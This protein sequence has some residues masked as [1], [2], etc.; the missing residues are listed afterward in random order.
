MHEFLRGIYGSITKI[1][2]TKLV[3]NIENLRGYHRLLK[4]DRIEYFGEKIQ[5]LKLYGNLE[6]YEDLADKYLVR[7]YVEKEIGSKY[8][9]EL[10]DVYDSTKEINFDQL[11]KSFVL[12]LNTGSGCNIICKDKDYFDKD[13]AIKKLN[14]WLKEDFSKQKKEPQYK[15]IK[16]KILCEKYMEDN[17]GQLLDYKFFCF[18][19][20]VEF[21]KVNFDRFE[22]HKINFYDTDWNLLNFKGNHPHYFGKVEKPKNLDKMIEISEKL[23]ISTGL[24]FVRIDLYNI[25]GEIY[26]G[27]IT[28]TPNSGKAIFKPIEKDLEYA[29]KIE[30]DSY[31][32]PK[33]LMIASLAIENDRLDGET[34]KN[35]TFK[36]YLESTRKFNIRSVDTHYGKKHR[37]KM[38]FDIIKNYLW[39]EQIIVS[40]SSR[41]ASVVIRF[42]NFIKNKKP[43]YY[44]VIGGYLSKFIDEGKLKKSYYVNLDNIYVESEILKNDLNRQG[45]NN[46]EVIHN[47]RKVDQFENRYQK[48]DFIK[49][50]FYGRIMKT[51]GI[52]QAIELIKKLTGENYKVSLDIYG[53]VEPEYLEELKQKMYGCEN[54][55]YCNVITPDSKTEYE[56][57]SQYD[58]F[59]FPTEHKG[60]GLPG[61]LIDC[62]IAGVAVLVSDW[63]Y[64][65]EYVE[66][67]ENGY[68]FEYR[69]YADMYIKAKQMIDQNKIE[70]FKKES[71]KLSSSYIVGDVLEDF[72]KRLEKGK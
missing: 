34:I 7:D 35:K 29:K 60:E 56:I 31:K 51:K 17:Q 58:V 11:P 36:S 16:K 30:L 40:N 2:P 15:N 47:F 55:R 50:V 22:G 52:E 3:L 71:L 66:D 27:E 13:K 26:F 44:F 1:L 12:K 57:L 25:D 20:K 39:C 42:F 48:S 61:A 72:V 68:I 23:A 33:I 41:G 70:E 38:S 37:I 18:N 64:A 45:L 67:G 65:R 21:L 59:V 62:Y 24:S 43:I 53:Q 10:I 46:V 4:K 19:G 28:L 14:K 32:K 54:I 63:T 8:L 49:F 9:I 6:T 69:N 5:W